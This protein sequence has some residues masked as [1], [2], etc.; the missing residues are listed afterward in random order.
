MSG[1]LQEEA[2]V[3][4]ESLTYYLPETVLRVLAQATRRL[5][6]TTRE[7][8]RVTTTYSVAVETRAD[9]SDP[10]GPVTSEICTS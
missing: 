8:E 3:V 6:L 2:A 10:Q 4:D 9:V 7:R 5:D 1:R